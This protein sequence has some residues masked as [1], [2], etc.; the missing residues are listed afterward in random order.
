MDFPT[1]LGSSFSAEV[2]LGSGPREAA[3]AE[4][5]LL[6]GWQLGLCGGA[7][8]DS[9]STGKKEGACE[10]ASICGTVKDHFILQFENHSWNLLCSQAKLKKPCI[11]MEG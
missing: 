2:Q 5:L 10:W 8:T 3:A 11:E 7:G 9:D 1:W 4:L 6:S